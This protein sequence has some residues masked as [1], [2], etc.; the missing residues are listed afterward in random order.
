MEPGFWTAEVRRVKTP[1]GPRGVEV[2]L[3][4]Y[5]FT[6]LWGSPHTHDLPYA[7]QFADGWN[8]RE[9]WVLDLG[10]APIDH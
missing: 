8:A 9:V 10:V 6:V 1:T 5:P 2:R 7:Q 4:R 3:V